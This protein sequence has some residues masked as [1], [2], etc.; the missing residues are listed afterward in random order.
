[1]ARDNRRGIN[2]TIHRS[3]VMCHY[4]PGIALAAGVC[5]DFAAF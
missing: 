1:M 5:L 3:V 4:S 2:H